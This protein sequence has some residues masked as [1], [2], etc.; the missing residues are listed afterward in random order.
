MKPETRT[1]LSPIRKLEW[2]SA[3]LVGIGFVPFDGKRAALSNC[4]DAGLHLSYSI[5]G[6]MSQVLD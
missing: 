2:D 3:V 6:A 5:S 1:G 4:E